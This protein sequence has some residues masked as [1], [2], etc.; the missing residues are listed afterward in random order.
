MARIYIGFLLGGVCYNFQLPI[1]WFK[2]MFT[3]SKHDKL[4]HNRHFL[5]IKYCNSSSTMGM[6]YI[7]PRPNITWNRSITS[8]ISLYHLFYRS[9]W[10]HQYFSSP[11]SNSHCTRI[12]STPYVCTQTAHCLHVGVHRILHTY[13]RLKKLNINIGWSKQSNVMCDCKATPNQ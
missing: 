10:I 3:S 9:I 5:K 8:G 11:V 12:Y 13:P 7:N 1:T 6:H 4:V 2:N